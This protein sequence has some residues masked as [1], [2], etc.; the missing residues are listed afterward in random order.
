MYVGKSS[1]IQALTNGIGNKFI[2]TFDELK[3]VPLRCPFLVLD[4][5][6]F[7]DVVVDECKRLFDRESPNQ[8]IRVRYTDAKLHF[9]TCR[10]VL[11]NVLPPQFEDEAVKSRVCIHY[12]TEP[13]Y[14][15][16]KRTKDRSTHLDEDEV[17]DEDNYIDD[18]DDQ[19]HNFAFIN[20]R[21]MVPRVELQETDKSDEVYNRRTPM[22]QSSS[23]S[24]S[25]SAV[26]GGSQGNPQRL[27]E[28]TIRRI[29]DIAAVG[30][31]DTLDEE[32]DYFT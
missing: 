12:I 9:S 25:S 18:E 16:S 23:S 15:I 13:L 10:I 6:D 20:S 19:A 1:Y 17:E 24:S 26:R 11:C 28:D 29:R 5:F 8:T 22:Q 2:G 4:D 31:D 3:D 21:T 14:D 7:K 27:D 30:F 32:E